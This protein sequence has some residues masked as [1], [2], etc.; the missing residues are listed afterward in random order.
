MTLT[1]SRN[2]H[3]AQLVCSGLGQ[4]FVS[5][6][7]ARDK[8]KTQ[9]LVALPGAELKRRHLLT[10]MQRLMDPTSSQTVCS[11][12]TRLGSPSGGS[13]NINISNDFD[14]TGAE[15]QMLEEVSSDMRTDIETSPRKRRILPDK[16]T[17]ALYANWQKLIPTLID[18]QL[19]Y[20]ARTLGQALEKT[21]DVISACGT[22]TCAHKRTNLLCLFFD[23]FVS[24]DVLSCE[25]SSLPQVLLHH[26]LFPTSP[27]QPRMAVSVDLLSFY[28]AL[29]ERLCDAINALA[30]ALKTHYSRRGFQVTDARVR[31]ICLVSMLL[32]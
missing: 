18:P 25:C 9:T 15:D 11:P 28:R 8:R 6:R 16:S 30:S 4:H 19:S 21:H 12:R 27:S 14:F 24:I 31:S 29:F 3:K 7:K 22:D 17:D 26:G 2:T 13:N 5:L 32:N 10:Q 20:H 1:N 23:R